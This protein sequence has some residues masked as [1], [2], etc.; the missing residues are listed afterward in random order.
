M[1]PASHTHH[2]AAIPEGAAFVHIHSNAGMA[3]V[4]IMPGRVGA[5]R[6]T[7]RLWNDEFKPLAAEK[8]T[9]SL[10]LRAPGAGN[11]LIMRSPAQD[12]DGSWTVDGLE[13][14]QA[15]NWTVT[16]DATLVDKRRLLLD[17]PIVIEPE[18]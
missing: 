10:M 8:L 4:T 12:Q 7:I 5:A 11:K 15:G 3:D 6:A 17:A 16:I 18:Q 14:P 1:A 2:N 9:F 13:L